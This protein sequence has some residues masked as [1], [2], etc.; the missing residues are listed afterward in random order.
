MIYYLTREI[1][2]VSS[3]KAD[4][5]HVTYT[6]NGYLYCNQYQYKINAML[7]V[8]DIKHK[9]IWI[10]DENLDNILINI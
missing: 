4:K 5:K 7:Y 1:D 3:I 9:R 2:S 8:V 6:Q 10:K